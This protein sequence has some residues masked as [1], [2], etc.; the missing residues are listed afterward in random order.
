MVRIADG[1][2]VDFSIR[3]GATTRR[4]EA[5]SGRARWMPD[6][7]AIAFVSVDGKGRSGIFVQEFRAGQDT[8]SARRPL[9]G[10]DPD[11][12]PETFAISPDGKKI[13]LAEWEQVSSL[14]TAEGVAGVDRAQAAK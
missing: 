12:A 6:G 5:V 7:K 1:T 2:L 3:L 9:A 4:L 11:W 14:M 10:F 13:C 8:A